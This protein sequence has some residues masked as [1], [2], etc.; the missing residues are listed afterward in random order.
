MLKFKTLDEGILAKR[1]IPGALTKKGKEY[2]F[3]FRSTVESINEN[4]E[5]YTT[6]IYYAVRLAPFSS[7]LKDEREEI[8]IRYNM[9]VARLVMKKEGSATIRKKEELGGDSRELGNE[10]LTAFMRFLAANKDRIEVIF[11]FG[12]FELASK[13]GDESKIKKDNN[14][15]TVTIWDEFTARVDINSLRN[16][17]WIISSKSN[18]TIT[19][20]LE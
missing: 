7:D 1:H 16:E 5:E 10:I 13:Y 18:I 19:T 11:D 3:T 8:D 9:S 14:F 15:Q 12:I 17:D 2:H 4:D 20:N 6:D